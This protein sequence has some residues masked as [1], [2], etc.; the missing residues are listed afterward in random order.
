MSTVEIRPKPGHLSLRETGVIVLAV[1]LAY[2]P[3]LRGGFVFDDWIL[4]VQHPLVHAA[5]G[6]RRIWLTTEAPDYYPVTWTMWWLEWQLWGANPFGYHLVNIVLHAVNA[7][8]IVQVLRRLE[9]RGAWFAGLVFAVHPVNVAAVAWIS[10]QKTMLCMGFFL[11]TMLAYLRFESNRQW[12]WYAASVGWFALSLLAKPAAV[13]WPVVLLGMAWWRKRQVTRRDLVQ[14]LPFTLMSV[15]IAPV[16]VWFQAV[17]V[18][19]GEPARTDG[20]LARLA[21][22]GWAVWFY[23]FKALVPVQLCMIYPRW[24]IDPR[25]L[26]VYLP[27]LLLVIALATCWVKRQTWGRDA[28]AG[29]GYFLVMLFPVLGF[30]DQGYY[31]YSFVADHWQYLPIVG[32]IALVVGGGRL[33]ARFG[34]SRPEGRSP[35][36]ILGVVIVI[37]L[38]VLTWNQSRLYLND[39]TL[40]RDTVKKNP[41]AWLAQCNLGIALAQQGQLDEAVA[42]YGNA[43]RYKPDDADT[44]SNLGTVLAQQGRTAEAIDHW[45]LALRYR[46]DDSVAHNYLGIAYSQQGNPELARREFLAFTLLRPNDFE[47]HANLG[48]VYLTLGRLP[49]AAK[50]FQAALR[51]NPTVMPVQ[52]SL[53]VTLARLGEVEG[54]T[55]ALTEVLRVEPSNHVARAALAQLGQGRQ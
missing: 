51:I 2:L 52:L 53:G 10:E 30:F 15:A 22:A 3:A 9:V 31:R 14:C 38:G 32:V 50:Q 35:R 43:L 49:E 5:D 54:A 40:W 18:L 1:A 45:R 8:L 41:S 6:L 4:L 17:R 7:I 47:A 39:E 27:G 23:L 36:L 55:A 12:R 44:L 33:S 28:L 29:A 48:S 19:G 37:F 24:Q 46:P 16:T 13:M 20:F 21:G 11:G 34:R 25:N 26:L 42:A